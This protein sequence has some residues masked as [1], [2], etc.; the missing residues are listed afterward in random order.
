LTTNCI[1]TTIS[2]SEGQLSGKI[3]ASIINGADTKR[4]NSVENP[5]QLGVTRTKLEASGKSHL[6]V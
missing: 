2:L 1:E 4:E 5:D 3:L 6:Y